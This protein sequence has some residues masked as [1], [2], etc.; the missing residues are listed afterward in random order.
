MKISFQQ[1]FVSYSS[2]WAAACSALLGIVL[3][4]CSS[5]STGDGIGAG[6]AAGG[7]RAEGAGAGGGSGAAQNGMGA[8]AGAPVGGSGNP[9]GGAVGGG[10]GGDDSSGSGNDDAASSEPGAG[11]LGDTGG[12]SDAGDAAGGE[13][14]ASGGGGAAGDGNGGASGDGGGGDGGGIESCFADLRAL[15]GSSQISTRVNDGEQIRLRLALETADRISTSGTFP[16][17]AVRIGLEIDG[18]LI[19]LDEAALASA[20]E[21]SLHNCADVMTFESGGQRY[22]IT[23]PDEPSGA[24]GASLTVFAGE[25]PVRGPVQL[26]TTACV[27]G[28]SAITQC[29]SGG[30]C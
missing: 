17:R 13:A 22:E 16:W 5:D 4:S 15:D 3:S 2:V 14:G 30:P 28:G 11:G 1:A 23:D 10:L 7:R 8:E 19:C 25:A 29:R 6:G 12:A 21:L 9:S 27:T 20:Y 24:A 26:P 18:R